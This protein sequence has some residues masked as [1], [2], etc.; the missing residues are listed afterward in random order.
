MLRRFGGVKARVN[1]TDFAVASNEERR[2]HGGRVR[3]ADEFLRGVA[4]LHSFFYE[5]ARRVFTEAAAKE[6]DCAMAQWGV[7]MT[8]YHP[9]WSPPTAEDLKAGMAAVEKAEAIAKARGF[10]RI[11]VISAVGTRGYY[12]D[13][14]FERGEYYLVK[15]L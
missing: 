2:G 9:I 11:A 7:A 3:L 6:S 1:E 10:G 8:Y 5:E 13:R 15:S 4:L 14:G 12:L